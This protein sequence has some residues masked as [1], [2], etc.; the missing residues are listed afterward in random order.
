V[1][2]QVK[3]TMILGMSEH[4]TCSDVRDTAREHFEGARNSTC[5][6]FS[7]LFIYI[8]IYICRESNTSLH[9]IVFLLNVYSNLISPYSRF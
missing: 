2:S 8:Y 6:S 3:C 5:V 7:L 1:T 4:I 9:F